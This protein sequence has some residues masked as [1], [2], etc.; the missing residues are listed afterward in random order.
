MSDYE[1]S[2]TP[3][4]VLEIGTKKESRVRT[5]LLRMNIA[6]E[7]KKAYMSSFVDKLGP[8]MA[9]N[10]SRSSFTDA[11]LGSKSRR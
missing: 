6:T 10:N 7:D 2:E 5:G 11:P 3:E 4:E 9:V 8:E 1:V